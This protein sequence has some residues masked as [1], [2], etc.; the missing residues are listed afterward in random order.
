MAY[1]ILLVSLVITDFSPIQEAVYNAQM[2]TGMVKSEYAAANA[3]FAAKLVYGG[4]VVAVFAF[5]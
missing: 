1:L 4:L 2:N 5:L 3:D